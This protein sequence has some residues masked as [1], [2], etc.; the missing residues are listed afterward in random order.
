[1]PKRMQGP[2]Q[3]GTV[4]CEQSRY[5]R[6]T[7]VSAFKEASLTSSDKKPMRAVLTNCMIFAEGVDVP[8]I[9]SVLFTSAKTSTYQIVQAV[10]RA[11]R[12][13]PGRNKVAHIIIPVY[14]A[15][16]QDLADAAKGTRFYLL[17]QVLSALKLYDE[18]VF[19]RVH[20]L[21]HPKPTDPLHP[22][23]RPNAPTNSSPCSVCTPKTPTT[24][25]GNSA[26]ESA[27]RYRNNTAT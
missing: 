26:L 10:G 25:S 22:V 1:M 16:G 8:A 21:R 6:L 11:L 19:H 20:Y 7:Q 15:P 13:V 9:D 5:E 24:A 17:Q 2:L 18:H 27:R 3:V 4:N 23:A 14:K 12:P